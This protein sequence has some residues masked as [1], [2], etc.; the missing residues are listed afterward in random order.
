MTKE[1]MDNK[2]TGIRNRAQRKDDVKI[3]EE[4]QLCDY[5]GRG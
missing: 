3:Y 4:R 2:S 5:K 1:L